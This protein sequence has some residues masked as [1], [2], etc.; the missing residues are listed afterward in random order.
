[1][2]YPIVR[3]IAHNNDAASDDMNPVTVRPHTG[4][5]V[6]RELSTSKDWPATNQTDITKI[7][8]LIMID[9][10]SNMVLAFYQPILNKFMILFHIMISDYRLLAKIS[11]NV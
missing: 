1:M 7:D 3:L 11:L 2:V 9:L 6:I 8:Q 10:T 5:P 4:Q